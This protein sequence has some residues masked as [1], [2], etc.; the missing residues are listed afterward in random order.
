MSTPSLYETDFYAWTQQQAALLQTQ[1][2]S[3]LDL[4]NLIEEIDALG[5]QQRQ[6]LRNRLSV[7]IGHLLKWQHQ[8]QRRSWLATIQIQR[9][10]IFE[11]LEENPS[12]KPDLEA[13]LQKAYQRGIK[14]AIQETE[15]P[16]RTFPSDCPYRLAELLDNRF[17]P[18]KPDAGEP[19]ALSDRT[20]E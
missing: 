9:L 13:A 1:Q 17:Y 12:L 3:Q 20:A 11:L 6:E 5:K 4:L 16:D 8:P 19:D 10:D 15:L 2:W 7:L 14:L 18:G